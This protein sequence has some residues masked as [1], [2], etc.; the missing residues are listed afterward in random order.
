MRIGLALTYSLIIGLT[1]SIGSLLPLLLDASPA[2][3]VVLLFVL[4]IL[5][6]F[7]GLTFS[8]YAGMKREK[9][10]KTKEFK[11]GLVLALISG[12]TSPMLNLGFVSGNSILKTAQALGISIFASLPIWIVVLLGGF[13]AN[14]GYA[15]YL[16][17]KA[18]SFHLFTQKTSTN[19]VFSAASGVFFFSG[20][21]I[22]GVA[23]SIIEKF[24][25]SIGWAVLMSLMIV[26]SNLASVI[27][28][29]W[30]N[31]RKAFRYQVI[32]ISILVLGITIMSMSFYF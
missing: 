32:S 17:I 2:P 11:I 12:L 23:S 18:K 28:G 4:G 13:V 1:A 7:I 16:L 10:Q 24:G 30:K 27:I 5:A 25:S 26:I 8:A 19:L 22:Y 20:L 15:A 21:V 31:S 14:F 29:E 9:L 3:S 6:M